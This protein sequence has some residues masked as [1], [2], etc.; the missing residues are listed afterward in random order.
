[1]TEEILIIDQSAFSRSLI[2]RTLMTAGYK[3]RV[4]HSGASGRNMAA[5]SPAP[6]LILLDIQMRAVSGY[7][8]CREL[9]TWALPK[10]PPVILMAAKDDA[11][12][13]HLVF[14]AG[15]VDY[16]VKPVRSQVLL[17]RIS[18]QLKLRHQR[19]SAQ[20]QALQMLDASPVPFLFVDQQGAVT[21]A[22]PAGAHMFGYPMASAIAGI[23]IKELMDLNISKFWFN[24][25]EQGKRPQAKCL[26]L[27]CLHRRGNSFVAEIGVSLAPSA[28]GPLLMLVLRDTRSAWEV[29]HSSEV[30][31]AVGI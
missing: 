4:A 2:S 23:Q 31:H 3:V 18:T 10:A 21:H 12:A 5:Q 28:F 13:P 19:D 24:A 14:E 25:Q 7:A 9:Q 17:A 30:R 15:A 29:P 20:N 16:V 26:T 22:N 6:S 27:D 11:D 1:M 8:V